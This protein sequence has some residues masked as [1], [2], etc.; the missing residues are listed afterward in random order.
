MSKKHFNQN[1]RE[2]LTLNP[3][4]LRVSEKSITYADE[5]KRLFIDQYMSGQTPREIFEAHGFDVEML[6]MKRVEQCADRWKKAYEKEGITGLADSRKEAALR[7]SKRPLS[8]EEIIAK[9]EAKIKLLEAQLAYVKKLDK[10]ERRLLANGQNLHKSDCFELIQNAVEHG[11]ARMTRYF[12]QLLG[13]SRSG[14]YNYLKSSDKRLA[15]IKADEQAGALI[16]KAFNRRGFKK[17]SRSIKMTLEN[18]YHTVYNLKRIRRLMR[19]LNLVCPHRK[20]NP[21]RRMAKATQEHRTL[22]NTLQRD[23]KKGIPGLVLLTDI[24]YLPYG[25]SQTAYLSTIL[26]ASTGEL[27]AHNLSTTFHLPLAMDTIEL[28]IR[29]RRL[30]L[31]QE[32]FIHS[33]QGGHYTSP[34]YQ[35]LLKDKGLGQSMSRRGNCWDNAPQESFYGHM[36]DHV[37]SRKCKSFAELE[38]EINRYIHYYN[39]FRYQWGLKKMTP[40]QYRNHLLSAA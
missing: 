29:Q 16:K 28:L 5:F 18:D 23:F 11:L 20:A 27:V 12:C 40:V 35:K 31:H 36:K 15:R 21:Y 30:T 1:E 39:N 34:T 38:R 10:N 17:G 14:Y 6:G 26:D 13:V 32:A 37:K 7:S 25:N 19:N 2:R 4:V 33:D 24:T 9:Q 3:H 8:S 22:E